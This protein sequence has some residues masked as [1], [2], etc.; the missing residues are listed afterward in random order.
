MG[1]AAP[2]LTEGKRVFLYNASIS[3]GA[4]LPINPLRGG[5]YI[6]H[7]EKLDFNRIKVHDKRHTASPKGIAFTCKSA[8]VVYCK[9]GRE[10]LIKQ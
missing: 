7:L 2:F 6:G 1:E 10:T 4:C 5:S 3:A 8:R 9:Q